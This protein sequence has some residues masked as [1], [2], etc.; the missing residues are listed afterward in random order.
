[1][2]QDR[3]LLPS[4]DDAARE[5]L[6][7][8]TRRTSFGLL[9]VAAV[10]PITRPEAATANGSTAESADLVLKELLR[11]GLLASGARRGR[12]LTYEITELGAVALDVIRRLGAA[13][14]PPRQAWWV[15]VKR[16]ERGRSA[17][18]RDALADAGAS[19]F[20]RCI[21][22][23]DLVATFDDSTTAPDIVS[24][25]VDRLRAAGA[26]SVAAARV[27]TAR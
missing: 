9:T 3:T 15:T 8:A 12:F 5:L 26:R 27:D 21:G 14:P 23:F 18:L 10:A 19:R 17:A 2:S 6:A 25:L 24:D 11:A 7:L 13:L 4:S 16:S 22:D 1:L 20:Y